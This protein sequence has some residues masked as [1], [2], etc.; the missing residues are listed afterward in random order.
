MGDD[1]MAPV[2][3]AKAHAAIQSKVNARLTPELLQMYTLEY[4]G[5]V[6]S[7]GMAL[8]DDLQWCRKS[9]Q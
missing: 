5:A 4:S 1:A 9:L 3:T 2:A 8:L 7:R 6:A